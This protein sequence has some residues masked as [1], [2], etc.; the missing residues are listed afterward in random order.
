[1]KTDITLPDENQETRLMP[2]EKPVETKA[3]KTDSPFQKAENLKKRLKLF[4]YGNTGVGKTV[5]SLQF[6]KPVMIDL[7]GGADLYGKDF[8]FDVLRASSPD[9]ITKALDW[10]ATNQHPYLS[11]VIDTATV[12]WDALQKKWSDIF[13]ARNKQSKGFKH[14]F[15]D[16]Q[17]KDWQTIKSEHKEF[18]RKLIALDMN[19]IVTAREKTKYKDGGF[20]QACGETFDG[21][22]SLPYEFDVVLQMYINAEGKRMAHVKK[23]RSNKLPAGEFEISYEVIKQAFGEEELTRKVEPVQMATGDQVKIISEYLTSFNFTEEQIKQKLSVYDAETIAELTEENAKKIIK[24][25]KTQ[26]E[27]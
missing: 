26:K 22:K 3:T 5:L 1:M 15:Y 6:P 18:V 21:E 13:L 24:K 2:N 11:L 17:V 4:L 9:E 27:K 19:V 8:K 14:E 12:Y 16:L 10:L 7:E 25:I 20:M 23:D